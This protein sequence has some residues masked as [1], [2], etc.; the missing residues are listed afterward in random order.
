MPGDAEKLD[1]FSFKLACS[2]EICKRDVKAS[3]I[4]L[5][6][7]LYVEHE[8]LFDFILKILLH[9]FVCRKQNY[10]LLLSLIHTTFI[11]KQ[12]AFEC[13]IRFDTLH[14]R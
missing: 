1:R 12:Q 11:D 14:R 4:T 2:V 9:C 13:E 3:L 5:L 7:V 10:P 6:K 8:A